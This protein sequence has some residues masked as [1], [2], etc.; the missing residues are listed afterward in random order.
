MS[1]FT[2]IYTIKKNNKNNK[3]IKDEII[4]YNGL[5]LPEDDR[6]KCIKC[7]I[8]NCSECIGTKSNNICNKCK[9]GFYP[10]YEDNKIKI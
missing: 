10:I 3:Y 2:K 8:E 9:S 7:S 4:C 5:F 1:F 6:T